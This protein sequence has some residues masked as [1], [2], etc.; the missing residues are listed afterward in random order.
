M[1]YDAIIQAGVVQ[2]QG[3]SC[4]I[5]FNVEPGVKHFTSAPSVSLTPYWRNSG[6]EV[7]HVET[8]TQVDHDSCTFISGNHADTDYYV[9][10]IAIS[11]EIV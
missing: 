8:I 11:Y 7:G 4:V 6:N 5:R 10:W 9:R 3:T 1:A 2:K